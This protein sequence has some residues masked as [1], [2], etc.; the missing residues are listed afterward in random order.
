MFTDRVKIYSTYLIVSL[1]PLIVYFIPSLEFSKLVPKEY[2]DMV[3]ILPYLVLIG[4]S[5]L[6]LKLNQTRI[7]FS[8][9]LLLLAYHSL[10]DPNLLMKLGIGKI[11]SRQIFA[12]SL[13]LCFSFLFVMKEY[14]LFSVKSLIRVLLGLSPLLL[15]ILIFVISPEAFVSLVNYQFVEIDFTQIP[16][17]GFIFFILFPIYVLIKK[18]KKVLLF[19]MALFFSLIPFY[20]AAHIG[21]EGNKKFYQL[22]PSNVF[23]FTAI[24]II[25]IYSIYK[26]YW[27]R[28]YIDPLTGI[29]NRRAFDEKIE[30]LETTYA[31]TI[32][33]ID[34]FKSFND[35]Y[36][37]AEGDSILKMVAY[38][39]KKSLGD[40][41]Y[42]YGGE[43]FCAVFPGKEAQDCF[44]L[45]DS[46]RRSLE[47]REFII[48]S[49]E[50]KRNRKL[51]GTLT[52]KGMQVQVT[53]SMGIASPSEEADRPDLVIINADKAL[54]EAKE[55]GRNKVLVY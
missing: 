13:P 54:Y 38:T 10:S 31:I 55:T 46:A 27:R 12:S 50:V 28:V 6:G 33:D 39:L 51:R 9:L 5:I 29:P 48:R 4:I 7:F 43:E 44:D 2:F 36:G 20:T 35:T 34:H 21:L 19:Q 1:I 42:R 24:I 3:M 22:L 25:L 32:M 45:V 17:I 26:M 30:S 8:S 23:C 37:H 15:Y 18:E 47:Q 41:V 16:Q 14:P 11:R 53:M 52:E 40:K 49:T